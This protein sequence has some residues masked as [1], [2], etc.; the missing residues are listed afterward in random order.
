MTCSTDQQSLVSLSAVELR[1]RIG[2]KEISPVELL[3]ACFAQIDAIN[4][5]I[6]AVTGQCRD[7]ARTE[8]KAAEKAALDG[9]PLGLLHGLSTGIK[10]LEETGGLLTT[11]GSPQFSGNVPEKDN[12]MVERVRAAGAV[13]VGKTN[14]PE[15]GAGAN[16]RNPVWGA[17]GSP[18]NPTLT[19][20]GSSG[21]SGAALAC[22]MLPVCSGSDTG[23]SLRIPGAF[24]GVVGFRPSPGMVPAQQRTLGWTPISVLGPM[25]RTV[26]DT[27]L[28]LAAQVGQ[29]DIDPLSFPVDGA[30]FAAP[31]P[32]DLGSLRVGWTEDYGQCPVDDG[33]RGTLRNKVDAM[34]HL[35]R[36]CDPIEIDFGEADRCFDVIRAVKYVGMYRDAYENDPES[37]GP[38]IRA[39][40]EIGANMALAE[41]SWAHEE[42]TRMFRRFQAL[43]QDYDLILSPTVAVSPFPWTD[44]YVT[45]LEGKTLNN[46][47]HWLALTYYVTLVTNPAIALP[48]GT[49]H[50]DMPFGL[51]VVG[52]FRGDK[53]LLN[54][55]HAMEQAFERIPEL[56][57]PRP[58]LSKLQ[59][60]TPELKSIVTAPPPDGW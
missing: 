8:A 51:Q 18:F 13:L 11:F 53:A 9:E 22:D 43:Y 49:D 58:D 32:V 2:A 31:E 34:R 12:A 41:F 46:Y 59:S 55:S 25:G 60:P 6:N 26:A 36:S 24:C 10:D 54:A 56:A 39:N 21:G 17:T 57:R 15:F 19:V 7:R 35:F 23:G 47:Y 29:H 50:K 1:A 20:G 40:Y 44:L 28:L 16:T 37:L 27:C 38:N 3:D 30:D 5:A 14:T 42:E 45:E 48:C 52:R 33:I 4:P